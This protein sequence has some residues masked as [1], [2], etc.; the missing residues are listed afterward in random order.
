MQQN[1]QQSRFTGPVF[2]FHHNIGT[3]QR[4]I[5]WRTQAMSCLVSQSTYSSDHQ[6]RASRHLWSSTTHTNVA[7]T[8]R[9]SRRQRHLQ[10]LYVCHVLQ[11]QSI[12]DHTENTAQ[13]TTF[14]LHTHTG[15]DCT[16]RVLS[17][18]GKPSTHWYLVMLMWPWLVWTCSWIPKLSKSTNRT[19]IHT[20]MQLNLLLCSICR[21]LETDNLYYRGLH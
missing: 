11:T 9:L 20:P 13:L 10:V 21:W 18:E 15:V 19:Q 16:I 2:R 1:E 17:V 12:A 6:T 8:G 5:N 3:L 4:A 7:W 14:R